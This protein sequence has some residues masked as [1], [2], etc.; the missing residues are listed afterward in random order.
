MVL[1]DELEKIL[2]QEVVVFLR[3]PEILAEGLRPQYLS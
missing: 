2:K 3:H 1:N